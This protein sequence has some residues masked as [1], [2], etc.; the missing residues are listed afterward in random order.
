MTTC[1]EEEV[2]V[3]QFQVVVKHPATRVWKAL[4]EEAHVTIVAALSEHFESVEVVEGAAGEAGSVY[5][6]KVG[7]KSSKYVN[8]G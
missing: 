5:L 3:E 2:K 7:N 4:V 8:H 6:L 1:V